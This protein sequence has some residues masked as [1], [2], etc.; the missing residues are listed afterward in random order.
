MKPEYVDAAK[1]LKDEGVII[2][3]SLIFIK[4]PKV[5]SDKMKIWVMSITI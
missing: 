2:V 3:H 1:T 5:I 4:Y